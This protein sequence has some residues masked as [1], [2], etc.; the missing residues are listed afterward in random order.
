MGS[1][2]HPLCPRYSGTLTPTAPTAIWLW[3]TF[4]FFFHE[5]MLK[6]VFAEFAV[7]I[8]KVQFWVSFEDNYEIIPLYTPSTHML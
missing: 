7:L 5:K 4:T 6:A 3:E 2:F 1:A 8:L